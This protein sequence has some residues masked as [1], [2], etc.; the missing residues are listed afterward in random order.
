MDSL[1]GVDEENDDSY[2]PLLGPSSQL[3]RG[4]WFDHPGVP[5]RATHVGD[6]AGEALG[7]EEQRSL[8]RARLE[9]MRDEREIALKGGQDFERLDE[10]WGMDLDRIGKGD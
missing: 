4:S 5:T 9:L 2:K 8:S 10:E 3:W 6:L 7:E 1:L